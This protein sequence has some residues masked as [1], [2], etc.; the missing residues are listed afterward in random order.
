MIDTGHTRGHLR[1]DKYDVHGAFIETVE[2]HNLFLTSGINQL[3]ALITGAS[4]DTFTN[5]TATIGIGDSNAPAAA[6]QTD[7]QASTNV[8][9]V[10]MASG[11]PVALAVGTAGDDRA[12]GRSSIEI[13][14]EDFDLELVALALAF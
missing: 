10:G 5:A 12:T 7:L 1:V 4:G 6:A 8:A 11:Y 14:R 2:A 9:Y 13:R 3:W